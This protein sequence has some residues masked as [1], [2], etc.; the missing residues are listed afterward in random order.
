MFIAALFYYAKRITKPKFGAIGK[1][2]G[3]E[4]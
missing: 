4:K 3:V 2:L 1:Y